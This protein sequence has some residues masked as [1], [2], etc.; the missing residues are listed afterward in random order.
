MSGS[1]SVRSPVVLAAV[2]PSVYSG[3]AWSLHA[4]D[5][6]VDLL[7]ADV[8]ALQPDRL[9][10][11]HRHEQPV[12]H[13]DQLLGALLIEDDPAVGQR[14][15]RERQ[16]GRHVGL[17]QAGDDVDRRPLGGQHEVDAGRARL[18]G[19]PHD[20]VLDVA[21]RRHHQVGELV[22]DRDDVRVRPV[23]ALAAQRRR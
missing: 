6:G 10:G 3:S 8:G 9:V 4:L 13:A 19:D 17:D 11:P 5:D 12:T 15:R 1:T 16:P 23:H 14:R 21:R 7:V 2:T 22:D 20:R 18:L